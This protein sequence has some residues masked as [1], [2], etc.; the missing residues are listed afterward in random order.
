MSSLLKI[1]LCYNDLMIYYIK[2]YVQWLTT[3][4]QLTVSDVSLSKCVN[5]NKIISHY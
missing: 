2:M 1:K 3:S 5:V 4:E